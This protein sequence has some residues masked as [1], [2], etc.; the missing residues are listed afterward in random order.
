MPLPTRAKRKPEPVYLRVTPQGTFEPASEYYRA[1]LR[2]KGY[3]VGDIVRGELKKPR[4]PKHHNLVFA[5]LR[6]VTEN[7]DSDMTEEQL[8]TILKIKMGRATPYTDS[9][10]LKVYWVPESIAFDAMDEGVFS[11]FHREMCTI[12]ARDYFPGWSPS[13]VAELAAMMTDP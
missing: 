10:T 4:Y 11:E 13:Q 12:I 1:Q 6:K 9:A 8:L 3:R 7:I 5:T 2:K